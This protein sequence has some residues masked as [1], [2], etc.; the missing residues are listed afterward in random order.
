MS[1]DARVR[2][3]MQP[4]FLDPAITDEERARLLGYPSVLAMRADHDP[5]HCL[6]SGLFGK[7]S[8][9]LRWANTGGAAHPTR[10][11]DAVGWEEDLVLSVQHWLNTGEFNGEIRMLWWWGIDPDELRASLCARLGREPVWEAER[12]PPAADAGGEEA[13]G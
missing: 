4:A 5:L 1:A 12:V 3:R 6:L 11:E 8:P 10:N 2:G 7:A 9:T 13:K